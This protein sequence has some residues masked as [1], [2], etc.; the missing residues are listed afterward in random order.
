[1]RREGTRDVLLADVALANQE[2]DN[3]LIPLFLSLGTLKLA[4]GNE[5]RFLEDFEDVVFVLGHGEERAQ[6]AARIVLWTGESSGRDKGRGKLAR[7]C[8][9]RKHQRILSTPKAHFAARLSARATHQDGARL[10]PSSTCSLLQ[11]DIVAAAVVK[12]TQNRRA[13]VANGRFPQQRSLAPGN[14]EA[15]PAFTDPQTLENRADIRTG[16]NP[17]HRR[18]MNVRL[19]DHVAA[20]RESDRDIGRNAAPERNILQQAA[21]DHGVAGKMDAENL[22]RSVFLHTGIPDGD[23]AQK[24]VGGDKSNA[25]ARLA[26][27]DDVFHKGPIGS[28]Q[29]GNARMKLPDRAVPNNRIRR[30]G[31]DADIVSARIRL[32]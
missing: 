28:R 31:Y 12:D 10:T 6:G 15:G 27:A 14:G 21:I 30:V 18:A 19:A 1:M 7:F 4:V 17:R 2:F 24:N 32:P 26:Q 11:L 23:P 8:S 20:A 3:R 25:G 29:I 9:R 22:G 13:A 5:G 16:R